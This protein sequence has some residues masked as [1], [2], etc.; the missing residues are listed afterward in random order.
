[1]EKLSY[2]IK[3]VE[4]M[5][6]LLE[7]SIDKLNNHSDPDDVEFVRDSVAARFKIL[8]ESSW[9]LIK[10]HLEFKGV[11]IST[12]TPKDVIIHSVEANFISEDEAAKLKSFIKLRNLASH[13]YDEP[14]YLLVVGAAPEASK[15]VSELITRIKQ[16]I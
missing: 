4:K 6:S 11:D 14:Q 5:L 13:I 7:R 16:E 10:L 9:K 3:N 8:I 12:S 1:M 15:L 2:K